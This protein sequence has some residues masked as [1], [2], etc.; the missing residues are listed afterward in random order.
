MNEQTYRLACS[1]CKMGIDVSTF[2]F[3]FDRYGSVCMSVRSCVCVPV[4]VRACFFTVDCVRVYV[5]VH[6]CVDNI[7][8][9]RCTN[10]L[11]QQ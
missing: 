11:C 7:H 9:E 2:A 6:I 3:L 5:C 1:V 10:K 8:R 4:C